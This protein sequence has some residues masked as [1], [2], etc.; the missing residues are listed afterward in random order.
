M[1]FAPKAFRTNDSTLTGAKDRE[2]NFE[3]LVGPKIVGPDQVGT[4]IFFSNLA[5]FH[6]IE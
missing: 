5:F 3:F 6:K 2:L 1:A 4:H